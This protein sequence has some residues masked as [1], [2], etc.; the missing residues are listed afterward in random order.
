MSQLKFSKL[1]KCCLTLKRLSKYLEMCMVNILIFSD[2]LILQGIPT[3]I[4]S[5]YSLETMLIEESKVLRQ[6]VCFWLI[7][8]NSQTIF[9]CWEVIMSVNLLIECMAFMTSAKGGIMLKFGRILDRSLMFYLYLLLLMIEFYV[10][11]EG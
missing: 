3:V 8:S 5:F 4:R 2:F 6:Y 1:R 10:C 11:T 9:I 7:K